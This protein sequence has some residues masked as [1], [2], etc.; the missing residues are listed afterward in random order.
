MQ[1]LREDEVSDQGLK[2]GVG[3]MYIEAPDIYPYS[4]IAKTHI[5]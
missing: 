2:G 3:I 5:L 1:M 4:I